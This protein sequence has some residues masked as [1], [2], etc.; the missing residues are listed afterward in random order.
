[1]P[2]PSH[3]RIVV[4]GAGIVTAL[5]QGWRANADA[6]ASGRSGFAPVTLFDVSRHRARLAA[7]VRPLPALEPGRLGPRRLMRMDRAGRLLLAAA[8]E[9]AEMAGVASDPDRGTWPV[10][11]ATTSAGMNAGQAYLRQADRTASRRRQFERLDDYFANR[12]IEDLAS[13]LGWS[14]PATVLANACASGANAIGHAWEW[15]RA[16]RAQ[17]AVTGGYEALSE[18]VFSGFDSLQA[19]STTSCRPFDRHRDGLGLGEGAAILILETLD[20]ARRR[21][22]TPLGELVGYGAATDLHHLTQPDP[23]GRAALAGM[24]EA[25]VAAGV[26]AADVDYLNAHG[27]GTPHNDAAEAAAIRAWAG[28]DA[29]RLAVSSTKGATGHLLGAAGAV[30]AVICLMALREQWLPPNAPTLEPDPAC[31]FR[32]L[33]EPGRPEG[34]QRLELALSNSFGFGGSNASLLFRR[35]HA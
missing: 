20:R 17:V 16:G 1:M 10:A 13:D 23:E 35:W 33:R 8:R 22:A 30:E 21:G 25:C 26:S 32:L 14:G 27:T 5:G 7:E 11:L 15:I 31:V 4:S 9:A 2:V 3:P 24:T 12:H 34:P 28:D 29:G 6:L 18:L 19:L